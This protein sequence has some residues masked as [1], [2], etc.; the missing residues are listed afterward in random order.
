MLIKAALVAG[1]QRDIRCHDGFIS[2][3]ADDLRPVADERVIQAHGGSLIPGLHDHHMHFFATAAL[4]RSVDCGS[5]E[6]LSP[7]GKS[8]S[9][10]HDTRSLRRLFNE[11]PA[12]GWLRG[13][14]YHESIA[15]NLDGLQL[16]K[17]V[18][19]RPARIQHRSGKVWILNS[20]AMAALDLTAQKNLPGVELDG[21]GQ[22]T[23][24]LFRLDAWLREQLGQQDPI[25]VSVLSRQMASYG[26]TGFTDTS[27]TNSQATVTQFELMC[28][29]GEILQNAHLMGDDSLSPSSRSGFGH[30]KILLDEDNLPS[31]ADLEVRI[32]AAREKGR[33]I[34]FHC[35]SHVETLFAIAALNACEDIDAQKDFADRI[36]HGSMIFDDV[37]PMLQKL[38][39][40]VVTQPGFLLHRGDQYQQNLAAH[41]LAHL[42]RYR[43]LLDAGIKVGLSSDA[44]YGPLNPWQVMH[45]AVS[46]QTIAGDVIGAA[47]CA[48]P[49]QALAGYLS[50]AN[51]PGGIGRDVAVGERADLC[52]LKSPWGDVRQRLGTTEVAYTVISGKVVYAC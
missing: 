38:N 25:D 51:D 10:N 34:A 6:V 32:R 3:I 44:P 28:A 24:R 29:R 46:R 11:L 36:E 9:T 15:G 8:V 26:I 42:Y 47:D 21:Q 20:L 52:L 27:A 5:R 1:V 23:G 13:V 2:A 18:S 35:V 14:N 40:S 33:G 45:C 37:L 49:E 12:D 43:T 4:Q 50:H 31:L 41:E 39:L 22:P 7:S 30:L 17:L 19:D 48:T 16:D